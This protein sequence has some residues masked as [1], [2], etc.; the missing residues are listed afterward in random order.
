MSERQRE[1]QAL[2]I[3]AVVVDIEGTTS[4][5]S[6]VREDL[7]GY[8]R[9]RLPQWLAEE[10]DGIAETVIEQTRELA[11]RPGADLDEVAEILRGWLDSDVK[12]APLK[13]AQGVICAQGFREG[14][15]Y[16]EFFPD[17]P[18]ALRAWHAAGVTLWVYSSG[19]VRNQQDWFTHARGGE[20]ASLIG[21]WFDLVNAG[22][23]REEQ[24]YRRIAAE[25]GVPAEEILFLSD[26]PD[27]LD[28]AVSA[29][30]QAVGVTRAGEPNSPRPPHRWI[31]SFAEL[32]PVA[33][34]H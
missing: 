23:K 33:A 14:A 10:P 17:A 34:A 19:S 8:T 24:S 26:H 15:L 11:G 2:P 30:W 18:A 28:A 13:T 1:S 22:P 16:G 7:Y 32:D 4:P 31:G 5:T 21:G 27:E 20:L 12:A 29:G 25:I 3:R 6:S 9:R